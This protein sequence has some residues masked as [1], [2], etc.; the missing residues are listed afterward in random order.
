MVG[1][2]L[3]WRVSSRLKSHL[4]K[5]ADRIRSLAGRFAVPLARERRSG[6]R[7]KPERGIANASL[8]LLGFFDMGP[9]EAGRSAPVLG[10]FQR[11]W[12][13]RDRQ[14]AG[15]SRHSIPIGLFTSCWP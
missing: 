15:S 7:F 2:R 5:P 1:A 9:A 3:V 12:G 4:M 13:N 6:V 8:G 14:A 10:S 11:S